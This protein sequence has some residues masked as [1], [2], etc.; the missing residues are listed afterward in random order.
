MELFKQVCQPFGPN[1]SSSGPDYTQRHISGGIR[2]IEKEL[3]ERHWRLAG[4]R[5][6]KT[7]IFQKALAS[8]RPSPL[9][10]ARLCFS[11]PPS[12]SQ[13]PFSS[14]PAALRVGR[15]FHRTNVS[16]GPSAPASS[17]QHSLP[18]ERQP[19]TRKS[20]LKGTSNRLPD[21]SVRFP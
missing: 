21:R 20:L 12:R 10:L 18:L 8:D 6:A 17:C 14:S 19:D 1:T 2:V 4:Q 15:S 3:I 5:D 13:T 9:N 7:P 11:A 16:S